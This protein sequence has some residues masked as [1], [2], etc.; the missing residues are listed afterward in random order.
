MPSTYPSIATKQAV[1]DF[2]F[3]P[4]GPF[5]LALAPQQLLMSL[6]FNWWHCNGY[7]V[8]AVLEPQRQAGTEISGVRLWLQQADIAVKPK[9]AGSIPA[10]AA[11][12]GAPNPN[13]IYMAPSHWHLFFV[14]CNR[15]NFAAR[16]PNELLSSPA[17]RA[18]SESHHG[19]LACTQS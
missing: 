13:L 3:R 10:C 8:K 17:S 15:G 14:F 1:K 5:D 6:A 12:K 2:M 9:V 11:R 16:S 4:I 19:P 18:L 7:T